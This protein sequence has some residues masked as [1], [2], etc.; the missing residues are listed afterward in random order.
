MSE[1]IDDTDEFLLTRRS[2][3]ATTLS[4]IL[5]SAISKPSS[6]NA[7]ERFLRDGD[8]LQKL[9]VLNLTSTL[10]DS[11]PLDPILIGRRAAVCAAQICRGL[12][13]YGSVNDFVPLYSMRNLITD[14]TPILNL[15][16]ASEEGFQKAFANQASR[17]QKEAWLKS[18]E[19]QCSQTIAS[20]ESKRDQA[21]ENANLL[22]SII[23]SLGTKSDEAKGKLLNYTEDF[24]RAVVLARA[25]SCDLA[26]I[27]KI[28]G[29]IVALASAAYTG[30]TSVMNFV[31]QAGATG[32]T[33]FQEVSI[34]G[35]DGK[36]TLT[37]QIN[38]T[39]G[40]FATAIGSIKG[41]VD[42]YTKLEQIL[43]ANPDAARIVMRQEDFD[44]LSDDFNKQVDEAIG[45]DPAV[46]NRLK[47]A[48]RQY[49]SLVQERSKKIL[50]RDS[51]LLQIIRI[52]GEIED[53][54]R[55][56]KHLTD[57][58]ALNASPETAEYVYE[59]KRVLQA[60][61][62]HLRYL[63]WLEK[64]ALA[65]AKILPLDRN[66]HILESRIIDADV[67]FL[68]TAHADF[69]S[70]YFACTSQAGNIDP[71]QV[72]HIFIPT[73][74]ERSEFAKTKAFRFE[75]KRKAIKAE[76]AEV[77]VTRLSVEIIGIR[78][79]HGVLVHSGTQTF[80]QPSGQQ[81]TYTSSP[82][83]IPI[84]SSK[85]THDLDGVGSEREH[86]L[87]LS[88]LT[89]WMLIAGPSTN[90]LYNDQIKKIKGIRLTF[91]GRCRASN[92]TIK[93]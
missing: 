67:K 18:S 48:A 8:N 62:V 29:A 87:G 92:I 3:L 82:Y 73:D 23:Q 27:V 88:P 59:A 15:A 28:V 77:F 78:D 75:V 74:R 25:G 17:E 83:A 68:S 86:Y 26:R 21:V 7:I 30:G 65:I 54:N 20:L 41:V 31:G 6:A 35:K 72:V 10:E 84:L 43:S 80:Y 4:T 90:G 44:H 40:A 49:V 9:D 91:E 47:E 66:F 55:T 50:E 60:A 70:Q 34:T 52:D 56:Y 19:N 5:G 79:F 76:L 53:Q 13:Y 16:L 11:L 12:N 45:V 39:F 61:R 57:Q 38:P 81:V 37:K 51:C 42:E 32:L 58:S 36:T 33:L 64:R 46:K 22:F 93:S 69:S 71:K 24:N 2:L 14:V 85:T 63:V 89:T 1:P